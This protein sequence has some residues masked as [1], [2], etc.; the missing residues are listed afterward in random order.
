M[1][2][3]GCSGQPAT[4]C[5]AG[6]FRMV[7]FWGGRG[8]LCGGTTEGGRGQ[9]STHASPVSPHPASCFCGMA[10]IQPHHLTLRTAAG[11]REHVQVHAGQLMTPESAIRSGQIKFWLPSTTPAKQIPLTEFSQRIMK[12]PCPM[13]CL[14]MAD[15]A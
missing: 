11:S 14:A 5:D 6:H 10:V 3:L 8:T 2:G 1:R 12:P 15:F 9:L 7:L 13:Y 4:Q